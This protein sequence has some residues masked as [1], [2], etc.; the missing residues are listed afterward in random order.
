MVTRIAA[1]IQPKITLEMM[2]SMRLRKLP[3]S[4][5]ENRASQLWASGKPGKATTAA[6]QRISNSARVPER[7]QPK[8]EIKLGFFHFILLS[9]LLGWMT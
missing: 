8:A 5:V 9:R 7:A 3:I 2:P 4:A 1:A 6:S